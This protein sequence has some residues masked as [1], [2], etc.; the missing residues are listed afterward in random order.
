MASRVKSWALNGIL[1][2]TAIGFT[3]GLTEVGLRFLYPQPTG[4]SHQ[5]PYGLAMHWPG[6]TRSLPRYGTTV[7]FNSAGMRDREHALSKPAGVFRILLLGDSF[8]EALQVPFEESFPFLLEQEL[9]RRTGRDIE[10]VNAGVSGWG[11]DDELRY[12]TKYGLQ[13]QPDLVVVAMTIHN[14]ISDNFRE[15]WHTVRN[16][17]LFEE[18]KEPASYLRYKVIELKAFLATHFQT[19][20]LWR[21]VRHRAEIRQIG[22]QLNSHIVRLFQ[23]PPSDHIRGGFEFTALLLQRIQEVTAAAGGETALVLL[24]LRV[25]LTDSSFAAF[26]RAANA[27]T[28]TMPLTSPQRRLLATARGLDMPVVDLLPVFR[29]WAASGG[30]DPY[31]EWD[32]HWNVTGHRIA[33]L[34]TTR[35][36]VAAGV[37]H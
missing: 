14:D 21:K 24:P 31:L 1:I 2:L 19:Y 28:T 25:Q 9:A 8:M 33:A 27:D 6:I 5:D 18:P 16:G 12:L 34:A 13:Y 10:V 15:D 23:E 3:L 37:I 36:L 32:G 17:V 11:T 20:Q 30:I 35:E 29:E 7:T 22:A 26:V 4:L